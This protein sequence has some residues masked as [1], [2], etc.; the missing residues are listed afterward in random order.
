MSLVHWPRVKALFDQVRQQPPGRRTAFLDDAC[1]GEEA[2]RLEVERLLAADAAAD[3]FFDTLGDALLGSPDDPVALPIPET[4]G[5]WRIIRELGRGGMGQVFEAVRADGLYEQRVALKLVRP[6]LAPDLVARFRAERRLLA[7]LEH[8]GIARLLDGGV[9]DDGRPY[10][11]MEFVEGEPMLTHAD[12]ARLGVEARLR[13]FL[14]VCEAVAYAHQKLIV[15]RDLKPNNLLVTL[16]G[17]PKLLDFGIAKLMDEGGEEGLTRTG[18]HLMTPE[19]AAPEQVTGGPVSTATDVYALGVLLFELLT[20]H[21]PY[22]F[23]ERSPQAVAHAICEQAPDRPSTVV[24]RSSERRSVHGETRTVTPEEVA[25][26][27]GTRTERLR[28]RLTGDL[29]VICLQ[30]LRKEPERRYAS[31]EALAADVRRHLE[32]RP[33][34]ARSDTVGYRVGRFVRRHRAGVFAAAAVVLALAVG[35]GAALWQA[36]RAEAAADEA[37]AEAERAEREAATAAQVS[38]FLVGIFGASTPAERR[39]DSLLVEDVLERGAARLDEDLSE[40]PAVRARMQAVLGRVYHELGRLGRADSL[41]SAALASGDLTDPD[42]AVNARHVLAGVQ[43]DAGDFDASIASAQ[44]ALDEVQTHHAGDHALVAASLTQIGYAYVSQGRFDEAEP[45]LT[46]AVAMQRRLHPEPHLDRAEALDNLGVL[47]YQQRDYT[48]ALD[49][50]REALDVQQALHAGRPHP[51]L[52]ISLD[53]V[54]AVLLA[55]DSLEQAIPYAEESVAMQTRLHAEPHPDL[56]IS[57]N[58]YGVL[59]LRA[60]RRAEAEE[61]LQEALD[62]KRALFRPD[63]PSVGIT[64]GWLGRVALERGDTTRAE[65]QYRRAHAIAAETYEPGHGTRTGAA[66]SLAGLLSKQGRQEE[67]EELYVDTYREAV[68][69]H[70]SDHPLTQ[71]A[72]EPLAGFYEDWGRPAEAAAYSSE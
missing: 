15:H 4:V 20:G 53:N 68:E 34:S 12:A 23:A 16:E 67:A 46:E 1:G 26:R 47:Y 40:Q 30:A 7:A 51:D 21:R 54:G 11:V 25:A 48:R 60:E 62:V 50:L 66:H 27:R 65:A 63:H 59:L 10:F 41:L 18:L 9:A 42:E 43:M 19:Y 49:L 61:V 39:G 17:D 38:D 3:A 57:L 72:R 69:T 36:D 64:T 58:N 13:L 70:G 52:A 45:P 2:L 37:H 6:G 32:G 55:L 28:R 33:V 31:V 5:P 35:L 14:A 8:P 22:V 29:D 56:A 71:K 44:A 24:A